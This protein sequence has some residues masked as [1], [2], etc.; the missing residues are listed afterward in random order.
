MEWVV[1]VRWIER[2]E[3]RRMKT[4]DGGDGRWEMGDGRWEMGDG[5][6]EMGDG[7]WRW[8]MGVTSWL[9]PRGLQLLVD[10]H[11][12]DEAVDVILVQL[13]HGC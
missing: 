2:E 1:V 6:W 4:E 9:V 11:L 10:H 12:A 13:E 5:R 7:R 3:I 8:E